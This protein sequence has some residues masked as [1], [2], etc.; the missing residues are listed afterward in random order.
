MREWW[1]INFW[2]LI[3]VEKLRQNSYFGWA[4]KIRNIV[5]GSPAVVI[6]ILLIDDSIP[7]FRKSV[8][9]IRNWKTF[10][11]APSDFSRF[12]HYIYCIL[13]QM[14]WGE[15]QLTSM[16]ASTAHMR[17]RIVLSCMVF[18]EET[19]LLRMLWVG[20]AYWTNTQLSPFWRLYSNPIA[21]FSPQLRRK[22][23]GATKVAN[24]WAVVSIYLASNPNDDLFNNCSNNNNQQEARN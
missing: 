10:N 21:S 8:D 18:L 4:G 9:L 2:N 3:N 20:T 22:W 11:A 17:M 14:L 7:F 24:I 6:F 16:V 23:F 13:S 15:S 1:L 5:V 19:R 12:F